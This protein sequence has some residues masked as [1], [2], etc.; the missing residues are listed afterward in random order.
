MVASRPDGIDI[1]FDRGKGAFCYCVNGVNG[2]LSIAVSFLLPTF[3]P[4]KPAFLLGGSRG[5]L[6]GK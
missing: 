5:R 1:A 4:I 6:E 2:V 3:V